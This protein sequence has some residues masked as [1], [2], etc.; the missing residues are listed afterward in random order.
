[1]ASIAF[2]GLGVM[3]YPMAAHLK[4]RG[5]HDVTV[6]NRTAAKAEKWVAQHG[7]AHAHVVVVH[8]AL[9]RRERGVDLD[10]P[11][12]TGDRRPRHRPR[13]ARV[14]RAELGEARA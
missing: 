5:G 10:A 1:M 12:M 8:Q 7:G 13:G 9:E 14:G 4:N 11:Q 6:Y 2:L 3:G